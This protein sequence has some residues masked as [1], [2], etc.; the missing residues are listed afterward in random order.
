MSSSKTISG[1]LM[2]T[3]LGQLEGSWIASMRPRNTDSVGGHFGVA[4]TAPSYPTVSNFSSGDNISLARQRIR[5]TNLLV[6][7]SKPTQRSGPV[8]RWSSNTQEE[9]MGMPTVRILVADDYEPWR[10]FARLNLQKQPELHVIGEVAD[11]RDAVLKAQEM[12]PDLLLLDINLPTLNGI[13][14][15]R[16]VRELCPNC[17]IVILSMTR[18]SDIANEAFRSGAHAYVIK[19]NWASELLPAIDAVL[20][21]KQFV[22]ACL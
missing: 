16:Q 8:G 20:T 14:V 15:T 2:I 11:G 4:K 6:V 1:R 5:N 17:K 21:G 3:A 19:S 9:F 22:S 13:E 7:P 12:Q 10:R 18:S